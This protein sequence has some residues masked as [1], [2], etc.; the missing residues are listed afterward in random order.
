MKHERKLKKFFKSLGP[1]FITGA[2][3][4]D[5]SGIATYSQTGAQ[6]GLRQLWSTIFTLPFMIVIQEM[7]GR[8]GLVTGVGLSGIIRKHYSKKLL[9]STI[10]LLLIANTIN[11]GADLGAMA[12]ALQLV[13]PISFIILL[14]SITVI[15]LVLEIFVSYH[16]YVR[17]LKY[18]ALSLLAYVVTVFL[19]KIDWGMVAYHTFIPHI[20]WNKEYIMNI[21]ALLG[22]TISP[23]LFFWQANEEV[24]EEIEEGKITVSGKETPRI[25]KSDIK[26]LRRDTWIGMIFS[27]LITFFIIVT[28]AVT[29]G[30]RGITDIQTA[31][32]AAL[33]LRPFG[34]AALVIVTVVLLKDPA[35]GGISSVAIEENPEIGVFVT[36][37]LRSISIVIGPSPTFGVADRVI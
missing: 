6:F 3:D 16:V 31:T 32:D 26:N 12:A 11:I 30:A 5:P 20:S 28:A 9:Y 18:F 19:I 14:I 4:D 22:T 33:A 25:T 7:C 17:I 8:I 10:S 29:L 24:E 15:T 34:T 13:V 21:V 23:Y 36:G 2:S 27:N 35:Q 37:S 1:G